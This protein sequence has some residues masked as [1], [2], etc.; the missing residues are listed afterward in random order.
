MSLILKSTDRKILTIT[1]NRPEQYNSFTEPMAVELQ[2]AL[3]EAESES[4]R[5]VVLRASGKAFCGGQDLKEVTD[6]MKLPGFT[7]A[8]TVRTSYNPVILQIRHLGKPVLCAVQGAA[9]GAG[10]NLALACDLVI[11]SK[12]AFFIQAFSQI[13]LIPDSGGTWFLPRLAGVGRANAFYLMNEKITADKAVEAGL[14]WKTTEP[15]LLEREV[16]EAA[17]RLATMPT[18]GFALYKKAMNQ[19]FSGTLEQ[20][21]ELEAE[22][23]AEAGK[24]N[25]FHEGVNAFLEKRPPEFRGK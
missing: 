5:C 25:D 8:D 7:L 9:A 6:K 23:Q 12:E 15:D 19:T 22:L 17:S 20:Q 2:A 3:R 18:R 10:A 14:I 21:L 1:L 11:A 16:F 24:S 13:G 4:V